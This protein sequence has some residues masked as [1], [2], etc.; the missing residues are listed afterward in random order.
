MEQFNFEFD[1]PI[2]LTIQYTETKKQIAAFISNYN[3]NLAKEWMEDPKKFLENHHNK[4]LNQC[5]FKA[6][7]E[8]SVYAILDMYGTYLKRNRAT[9]ITGGVFKLNNAALGTKMNKRCS[10]VTAWRHISK[11]IE[12][13][14][15][16]D[17]V[18]HGSKASFDIALNPQLLVSEYNQEYCELL[19]DY[20]C[21]LFK[22]EQIPVHI[23]KDLFSQKPLFTDFPAGFMVSS[24]NDTVANKLILINNNMVGGI[25]ASRDYISVYEPEQG[26][27]ES[28]GKM[29]ANEFPSAN[30]NDQGLVGLAP[31]NELQNDL[32]S[33][34]RT[35]LNHFTKLAW[36]FAYSTIFSE[37]FVSENDLRQVYG[38]IMLFF[39]PSAKKKNGLSTRYNNFCERIILAMKWKNKHPEYRFMNPTAYFNPLTEK[40]FAATKQWLLKTEKKREKS[41]DYYSN[42]KLLLDLCRNY[43]AN[44]NAETY[45]IATQKLGKLK[46]KSK[47]LLVIFNEFVVNAEKITPELFERSYAAMENEN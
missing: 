25:S 24:C 3:R 27:V 32:T 30:L 34:E 19:V 14:I 7:H 39:L 18:F 6:C 37:K 20:W 44:P 16:Q 29:A 28:S 43:V 42:N 41:K 1:R 13:G 11:A 5:K 17:K 15:L 10:K 38:F 12:I 46:E 2:H 33:D 26:G 35:D 36:T 9:G 23:Y 22:T 8:T 40:G 21:L 31:S 4:T 45:R 47:E